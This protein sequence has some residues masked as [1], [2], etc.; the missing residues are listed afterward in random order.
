[1]LPHA[2]QLFTPPDAENKAVVAAV[3]KV[4]AE[5]GTRLKALQP[6]LWIVFS[7]DHAEPFFQQAHPAFTIH[8]GGEAKELFAGHDSHWRCRARLAWH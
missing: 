7:N 5:I 6:N 8:V 3:K 4:G 2:P 1:M